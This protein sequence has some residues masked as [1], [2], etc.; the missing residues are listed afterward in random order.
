MSTL[1]AIYDATGL[2]T[3]YVN[4]QDSMVKIQE[5]PAGGGTMP[6]VAVPADLGAH[7]KQ[8]YV[9]RGSLAARLAMALALSKSSLIANGV[10][11]VTISGIPTGAKATI[12]GVGVPFTQTISDGE[13]IITSNKAGA[14]SV[15]IESRPAFQDW[16]VILNAT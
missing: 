10:D 3:G 5:Y 6:L 9:T 12:S 14:I 4:C 15:R 2:I 1:L 8:N 13:L 16:S 7:A 11:E